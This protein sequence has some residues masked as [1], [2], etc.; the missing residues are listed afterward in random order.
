MVLV[1]VRVSL[2]IFQMFLH[3]WVVPSLVWLGKAPEC[4]HTIVKLGLEATK[5]NEEIWES[6]SSLIWPSD[7]V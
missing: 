1:A 2:V 6:N 7:D 4:F 5:E 3:V